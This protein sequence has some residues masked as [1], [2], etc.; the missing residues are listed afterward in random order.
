SNQ[1]DQ[2]FTTTQLTYTDADGTQ[3][4]VT[5]KN[6]LDGA[7]RIIQ[8]G[9]GTGATPSSFDAVQMTYDQIGRLSSQSNPYAADQNGAGAPSFF[10]TNQYDTLSR[11]TQVTLP[12]IQSVTR[13]YSGPTTTVTD[14]V[15]RKRSSQVDGLGRLVTVTEQ[16][17]GTG[18]L[19]LSTT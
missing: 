17:P 9:T 6:W 15:G 5:T 11:V 2:L 14:Q 16:D 18:T 3:K 4:V 7:G 8:T 13:T 19:S 12:G 10:T 1:N